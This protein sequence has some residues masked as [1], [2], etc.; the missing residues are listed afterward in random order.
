MYWSVY[1]DIYLKRVELR[2][3]KTSAH[4]NHVRDVL[5]R[6]C[7]Y[8]GL[9]GRQL[10]EIQSHDLE[11]YVERRRQDKWRGKLLQPCTINN[12]I[13]ILNGAFSTA[14]PKE[15]RGIGRKNY[16]FIKDVPYVEPLPEY[17]KVPRI[18]SPEQLRAFVAAAKTARTPHEYVCPPPLFWQAALLLALVTGLRRKALLLLPRPDDETLIERMEVRVPAEILKDRH[19]HVFAL[20]EGETGETVVRILAQLPTEVGEPFLPWRRRD[21]EPLG[22]GH[23]SNS[24]ARI[25]RAAG[26]PEASRF[27]PKDVRSTVGTKVAN[28]FGEL[29]A[30]N[31]LG[32]SPT[33]DTLRKHYYNPALSDENRQASNTMAEM[34]LPH[35]TDEGPGRGP[36]L[37]PFAGRVG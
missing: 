31:A 25:Q 32:H 4:P 20:G 35:L 8:L 12:E 33:T 6:F 13:R 24:F 9:A 7:S 5:D 29:I 14:G 10:E 36:D 37:V 15:S 17:R 22:H 2:S 18:V 21:G 23:F 16:G 1:R 27:R 26:I 28:K 3:G 19:E 11:H 34:L 30:K